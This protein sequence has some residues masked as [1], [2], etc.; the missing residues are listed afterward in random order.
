MR[1][2]AARKFP[3]LSTRRLTPRVPTAA[4]ATAFEVLLS[5]PDVTRHSNW[6]DAPSKAQGE[7][8]LR[9]KLYASGKG[10]AWI[11]EDRDSET[12]VVGAIRFNRFEKKWKFG[13]IG[14]ELHPDFWGKGPR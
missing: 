10:C 13:E 4:D 1:L 7:R 8:Y 5:I 3:T 12:L 2:T 9:S 6:P 11:I 14:Y